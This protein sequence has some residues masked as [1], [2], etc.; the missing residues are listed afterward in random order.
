MKTWIYAST[1]APHMLNSNGRVA[2][3]QTLPRSQQER[4]WRHLR[5]HT[6]LHVR[7]LRVTSLARPKFC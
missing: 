4:T 6:T 7:A 2:H 5:Q 3:R 1:Q